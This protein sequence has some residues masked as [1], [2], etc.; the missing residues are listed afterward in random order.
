ML[1]SVLVETHFFC[2]HGETRFLSVFAKNEIFFSFSRKTQFL[3]FADTR[4]FRF[5]RECNFPILTIKR[6]FLFRGKATFFFAENKI[7]D[8]WRKHDFFFVLAGKHNFLFWREN[9]FFGFGTKMLFLF[10][11]KN[12]IFVF[13][14]KTIFSDLEKKWDFPI[15]TRKFF[16][17]FG[18][19]FWIGSESAIFGLIWKREFLVLMGKSFCGKTNF[20]VFAGKRNFWYW[21]EKIRLFVFIGKIF[22]VWFWR[23]YTF[24]RFYR[25]FGTG[26]MILGLGLWFVNYISV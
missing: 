16:L 23:E 4:L 20:I 11:Y 26:K 21:R 9:V 13:F 3:V 25:F 15:L 6:F 2:F 7:F 8:F 1:F 5:L 19:Y 14:W 18:G 24:L 12:E 22:F 17:C 10:L